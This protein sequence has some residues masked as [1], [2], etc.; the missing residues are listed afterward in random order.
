MLVTMGAEG[1]EYRDLAAGTV[2]RQPAFAVEVFD[3]TGA[4]DCFT[5]YLAA[6]LDM[7]RDLPEAMRHAAAASAIKVTRAG[8]GDAIPEAAEVLNFLAGQPRG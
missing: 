4:G 2:I 5:G 8:A 3:T 6:G 1:A 7:G